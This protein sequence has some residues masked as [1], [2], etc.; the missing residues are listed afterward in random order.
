MHDLKAQTNAERLSVARLWAK[1]RAAL[2]GH[3]S[4][5]AA[6]LPSSLPSNIQ[7]SVPQ[8]LLKRVQVSP[9][10]ADSQG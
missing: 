5:A 3:V 7:A 6:I 1:R 2:P 8:I 10:G 4:P 9:H